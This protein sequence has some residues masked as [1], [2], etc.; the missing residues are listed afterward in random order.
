MKNSIKKIG[1]KVLFLVFLL[2]FI[3]TSYTISQSVY[4]STENE[5]C[6]VHNPNSISPKLALNNCQIYGIP[7]PTIEQTPSV[8]SR[9]TDYYNKFLNLI[10]V[11]FQDFKIIL[12]D[13]EIE[14]VR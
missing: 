10:D 8:Q 1:I 13:S 4:S 9:F 7:I 3:P 5:K 12:E 2:V 6:V 14:G 11:I